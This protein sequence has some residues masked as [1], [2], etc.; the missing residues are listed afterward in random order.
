MKII[1]SEIQTKKQAWINKSKPVS[2]KYI[3]L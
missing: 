3:T 2:H 1:N